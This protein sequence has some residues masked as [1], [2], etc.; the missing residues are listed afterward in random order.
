MSSRKS[1]RTR[2]AEWIAPKRVSQRNVFNG[3]AVN[4]LTLDWIRSPLSADKELEGDFIRLRGRV[5]DLA[6]NNAY[7]KRFIRMAR[8]HVVGPKGVQLRPAVTFAN[9]KPYDAINDGI[10]A[11]WRDWHRPEHASASGRLSWL[12]VQRLAMSEWATCGEALALLRYGR[13]YKYGLAVQ[14]VDAD[15]LDETYMRAR[16]ARTGEPEIRSGVEISDTGR[17]LA[18]HILQVHPSEIGSSFGRAQ[19][20]QRMPADQVIHLYTNDERVDLTRGVPPLAVAMRDLRQ[21]DGF[22]EAALVQ[23][24]TAAAAMGFIVTKGEDGDT[25]EP[26]E[27]LEFAAETGVVRELG[28]GQEF[29]SWD[30]NQPSDTYAGFCKAV[31]RGIAAG[32]G[33]SYAMMANDLSDANYS[34]MRVGRAE[35]QETWQELQGWFVDQFVDRVYAAWLPSAILS[36]KLVL[37]LSEARD[38][39]PRHWIPRRWTSVDP[40]KDVE[41]DER[42]VA[43]GVESRQNIAARD[44]ADLW[45]LIEQIAE[46]E[47]YAD[48]Y[49]VDIGPPRKAVG[50]TPNGTPDGTAG[51]AQNDDAS[52]GRGRDRAARGRRRPDSDLALLRRAD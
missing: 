14:P 41:A 31:L 42:R 18:Y 24:R 35:E 29:Q 5:R 43:L 23:A 50:G 17:P 39:T 15:R 11:A 25:T 21:L 4:R 34:S 27:G 8:A 1:L 37:P 40:V 22:Q 28:R 49:G 52:A 33:A 19:A 26:T 44:G 38:L 12:G 30:P 48:E 20:R 36:G 9:G 51:V 10:L 46:E 45:E 16:N 47:A 6:R 2:V 13:E 32:L 7:A 3:A